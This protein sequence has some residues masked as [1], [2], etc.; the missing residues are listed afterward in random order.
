M[1]VEKVRLKIVKECHLTAINHCFHQF[2]PR[3]VSGV[4]ILAESHFTIH[5]WPEIN[6]AAVDL[7]FAK[8]WTQSLKLFKK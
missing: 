1:E 3:D 8:R 2:K 4:V 6:Y 7:L 5:T